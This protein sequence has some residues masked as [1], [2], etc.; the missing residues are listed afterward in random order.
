MPLGVG[1]ITSIGK[2]LFNR[3]KTTFSNMLGRN[4]TES[5]QEPVMKEE[6]VKVMPKPDLNPDIATIQLRIQQAGQAKVLLWINYQKEGLTSPVA[7]NVEPYSYRPRQVNS[8]HPL[9]MAYCHKD[10]RT[11]AFILERI[12]GIMVTDIPFDP[13]W[14]VEF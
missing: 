12:K 14:P 6:E 10:Q 8:A 13:K 3:L 1:D 9:F 7:R 11:E 4:T 5:V 2:G